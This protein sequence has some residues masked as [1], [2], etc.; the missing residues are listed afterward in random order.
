MSYQDECQEVLQR[1]DTENSDVRGLSYFLSTVDQWHAGFSHETP[2]ETVRT[3]LIKN[4]ATPQVVVLGNGIPEQLIYA[5]GVVPLHVQGGS[6]A[7]CRWSDEVMPRDADPVSRSILGYA[8]QIA[9]RQDVN[10]LFVV[11]IANDNMRKISYLLKRE[12]HEVLSVDVPPACACISDQYAWERSMQTMVQG[13]QRHVGKRATTLRIRR[14]D[15]LVTTART[16]MVEFERAYVA[17][18]GQLSG[19]AM[20]LVLNSYYQ[21][22]N[23]AEWIAALKNLTSEIIG[24]QQTTA[25]TVAPA[26]HVLVIGSPIIFP[27]YKVPSLIQDAGL[28]LAAAVDATST[29]RHAWLT[30]RER[31]GGIT[32][33]TKAI[34][35]RHY[36][37]DS[38]SAHVVNRA[39]EQY[40]KHLLSSRQ[41]DGIICHILKGQIEYDFELARLESLF[42]SRDIPVFRLETDYQYQD[43]EQLRIRLEAFSE[44]LAQRALAS[45][46][47][48]VTI[49]CA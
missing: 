40:V 11:P 1:I 7:S 42:E 24:G 9:E 25:P 28:R 47:A 8:L 23:L 26:P 13:V 22:A 48:N 15:K 41:V 34:A 45:R 30:P 2:G 10:P 44:M 39:L 29:A 49:A 37:A 14:A 3:G 21:T 31:R 4:R 18:N 12:G 36:T 35:R 5:C 16:A 32:R 43:V 19:E 33:L 27:Q 38:S 46:Q 17:C 6:H 20:L